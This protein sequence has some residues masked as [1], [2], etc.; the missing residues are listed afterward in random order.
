MTA[1]T[2]MKEYH[3]YKTRAIF[4]KSQI[5]HFTGI[6]EDEII[7]AMNFSH[8]QGERV[9]SKNISNKTAKIAVLYKDKATESNNE[10][11]SNLI[12][13]YREVCSE[14]EFFENTINLLSGNLPSFVRKLVIEGYS[15][16]KLRT[17]YNVSHTTVGKY[18]RKAIKELDVFY[19]ERDRIMIDYILS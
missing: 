5:E 9:D 14:I 12:N 1:K 18:R 15:W 4:L 10:W 13:E 17:E 2:M 3:N 6:S 7:E 19:K 16:E 8:P 11:L